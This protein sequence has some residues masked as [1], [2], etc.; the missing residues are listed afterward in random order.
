MTFHSDL[1]GSS[2]LPAD[3][4]TTLG[5]GTTVY[6]G[7]RPRSVTSTGL[8]VWIERLQHSPRTTA[9]PG[10]EVY[11]YD[12]HIRG[13]RGT[14]GSS[15]AGAAQAISVDAAVEAIKT[16]YDS[17]ARLASTLTGLIAIAAEEINFDANPSD[18]KVHEAVVRLSFVVET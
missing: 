1:V 11:N 7:R 9:P 14:Q 8:E 3:L 15:R 18:E 6:D 13:Q 4:V 16:R 5:A 17:K 10:V 12:L 2:V